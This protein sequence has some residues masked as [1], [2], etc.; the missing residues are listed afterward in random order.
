MLRTGEGLPRTRVSCASTP[1]VASP[2]PLTP[3]KLLGVFEG[4]GGV[5]GVSIATSPSLIG[6]LKPGGGCKKQRPPSTFR[7]GAANAN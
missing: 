3:K 1:V 7:R 4:R 6:L 5:R 2:I